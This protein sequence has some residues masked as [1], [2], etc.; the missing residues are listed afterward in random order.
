MSKKKMNDRR[1]INKNKE[2]QSK[3][4]CQRRMKLITEVN[5]EG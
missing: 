3:E 2:W 4:R 1:M 5:R